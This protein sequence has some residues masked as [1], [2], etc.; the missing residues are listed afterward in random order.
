MEPDRVWNQYFPTIKIGIDMNKRNKLTLAIIAAQYVL[1]SPQVAYSQV[2]EEILSS[3]HGDSFSSYQ[4]LLAIQ[5]H[6]LGYDSPVCPQLN[7]R[8]P[9]P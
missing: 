2:L 9:F 3:L 1:I 4:L 8:V 6:L 7:H 5:V